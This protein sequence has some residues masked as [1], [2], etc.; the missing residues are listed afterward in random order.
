AS[1]SDSQLPTPKL[2]AL[3]VGGWKLGVDRHHLARGSGRSWKC[4]VSGLVPFPPSI[5]HGVRSPLAAHTP[6]PFQPAFGSSMRP[7]NPLAEKPIGY[8]TRRTTMRPL[9]NAMMPS[10]RLPVD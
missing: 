4:A 1:T 10:F 6:R 2:I 7:A 5:S 9:A 3:R 8:G